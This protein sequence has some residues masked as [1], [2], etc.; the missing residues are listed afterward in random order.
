MSSL[1]NLLRFFTSHRFL[2]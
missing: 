2:F 1:T